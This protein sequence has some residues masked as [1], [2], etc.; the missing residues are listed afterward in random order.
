MARFSVLMANYNNA[1][2]LDEAIQSVLD[3]TFEDWE[4]VIV[5][6][7]SR[8]NSVERIRK[9]L[10]DVRIRLY[11]KERNE[12]YT[13]ALIFGLKKVS[14]SIVGFL[15]SDDAL[16]VN[17]IERAH[18]VHAQKPEIG[19]VLSQIIFCDAHLNSLEMT[20]AGSDHQKIPLVWM[21]GPNHFRSF[22]MATYKKTAG[23]DVRIKHAEDWDLVFKLEEVAPTFRINEPLYRYRI[24]DTSASHAPRNHSIGIR[25][26]AQALYNAHRRRGRARSDIPQPALLAR[27]AAAVR[28]SIVLNEP[29]QAIAFAFRALRVAPLQHS[30]WRAL[31]RA[32][33]SAVRLPAARWFAPN[34]SCIPGDRAEAEGTMLRSFGM[35]ALQSKT[36]NIEPDCVICIP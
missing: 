28:H 6:D 35:N 26:S 3:Q 17:A 9:Y 20:V 22:K 25:S 4:L 29:A 34:A 15:D 7:A 14:S 21:I 8:D 33:H 24:L 19:L 16:T 32:V 18:A 11:R 5:D 36:G 12:G 31:Y 13:K 30:S 1:P 10:R 27:L 23:L 2:F